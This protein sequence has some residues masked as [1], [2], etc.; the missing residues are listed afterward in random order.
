MRIDKYLWCIRVYKTRS[1]AAEQCRL[2][3][4]QLNNEQVKASRDLKVGDVLQVRKGPVVFQWRVLSFPTS[5]VGAKLVPTYAEECTTA[6]ERQ[7]LEIIKLQMTL[8]RPRGLG[9][10]TKKD[11]RSIDD[12][13]DPDLFDEALE[14]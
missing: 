14:E 13:F 9:R 12:F 10:P 2:D 7:K 3:K 6:D 8:E 5:R 11:R 1:L 4:V